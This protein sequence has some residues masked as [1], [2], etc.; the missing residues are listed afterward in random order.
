MKTSGGTSG[1]PMMW[2]VSSSARPSHQ[3]A[4]GP[5]EIAT[6]P[7]SPPG[8]STQ[9]IARNTLWLFSSHIVTRTILFLY[10]VLLARQLGVSHFGEYAYI[11]TYIA[12]FAVIS[13]FGTGNFLLRELPRRP[14]KTNQYFGNVVF[15]RLVLASFAYL[16]LVLILAFNRSS[17]EQ[18][19]LAAIFGLTLF[20]TAFSG[21][22]ESVFNASEDMR[23]SALA[24]VLSSL[25]VSA[26]GLLALQRGLGLRGVLAAAVVASIFMAVFFRSVLRRRGL[27]RS[28]KFEPGANKAILKETYPYA[29]LALLGIVYFKIDTLML[30]WYMGREAVGIY[31]AAY[32]VMES[33]LV[34]P[35]ILATS[36]FPAMSRLH[37]SSGPELKRTYLAS[38]GILAL[39]GAPLA[40]ATWFFAD[41]IIQ[42]LYG[43]TYA[44]SAG[45]LRILSL[46]LALFFVHTSNGL[47]LFS[48]GR[49]L[50]KIIGLSV[51]SAGSNILMNV[52][53]IPRFSYVGASVTTVISIVL[54]LL[55]FTPIVLRSLPD[56]HRRQPTEGR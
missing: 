53:A 55:I 31:S 14:E 37:V 6:A 8:V 18:L 11:V 33:T 10:G 15:F 38:M 1:T 19:L 34:I 44:M 5:E 27:V 22:G 21:A 13:E 17:E 46:A 29:L 40:V 45:A 50:N 25:L 54:S 56:Q 4:G 41:S 39:L 35:A 26:L 52:Y 49:G 23:I 12:F 9:K 2:E 30:G 51:L 3:P 7:L 24:Q 28:M 36:L 16:L 47:F 48:G 42:F 32:R 20:P 43:P